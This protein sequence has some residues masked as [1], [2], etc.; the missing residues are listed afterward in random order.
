[1]LECSALRLSAVVMSLREVASAAEQVRSVSEAAR[2][3]VEQGQ[4][5]VPSEGMEQESMAADLEW[6]RGGNANPVIAS[7]D[8]A[9]QALTESRASCS[10]ELAQA[11]HRVEQLSSIQCSMDENAHQH[12]SMSTARRLHLQQE[13]IGS[14]ESAI[15]LLND[16][17]DALCFRSRLSDGGDA[18][19]DIHTPP[20][21]LAR[22]GLV[23]R[24]L[25]GAI[26][27]LEAMKDRA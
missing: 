11:S 5:L 27:D 6:L 7:I 2:D 9:I 26:R 13:C 18:T 16:T 17:F 3:W 4:A 23:L 20:A 8:E 14:L 1:M 24:L 15:G 12:Y 25:W 22:N 21:L 19:N 10:S